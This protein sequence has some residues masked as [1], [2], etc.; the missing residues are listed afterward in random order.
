[1][2]SRVLPLLAIAPQCK[3]ENI[4]L[5]VQGQFGTY[6]IQIPWGGVSRLTDAGARPISIPQKLLD[7]VSENFSALPI[8]LDHRTEM[9]LR[10]AFV[11]AND[12][13][14]DSPDFIRQLM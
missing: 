3:I 7:A 4:W 9:I 1:M 14:V 10:K 5:V 13:N 11:I 8:D 6:R 2:L 12:W